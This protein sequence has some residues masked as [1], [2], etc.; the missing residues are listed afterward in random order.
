MVKPQ[1]TPL[2]KEFGYSEA[3]FE[4]FMAKP[5]K[6]PLEKELGYSEAIF[7]FFINNDEDE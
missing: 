6:T 5:Q 1:K 4:F 3:I 2:E 7:E